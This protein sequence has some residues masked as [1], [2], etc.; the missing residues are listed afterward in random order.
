MYSEY[1]FIFPTDQPNC[2]RNGDYNGMMSPY[3]PANNLTGSSNF[4]FT[5]DPIQRERI[6][7]ID[8]RLIS[9]NEEY[10][11]LSMSLDTASDAVKDYIQTRIVELKASL[12]ALE[13]ER[14][15]LLAF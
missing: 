6:I 1:G 13:L 3:Q 8:D 14:T 7:E 2:V 4:T 10:R 9:A 5:R 12:S 15:R 11:A